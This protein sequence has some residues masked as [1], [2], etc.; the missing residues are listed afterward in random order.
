MFQM[1][2]V[3][4]KMCIYFSISG[5][6]QNVF[7]IFFRVS[8]SLNQ[9]TSNVSLSYLKAGQKDLSSNPGSSIW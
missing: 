2:N 5:T 1:C 7:E 9:E 8:W 3:C 6:D 4:D